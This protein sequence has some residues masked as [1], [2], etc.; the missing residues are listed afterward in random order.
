ML[1][2]DGVP[3]QLTSAAAVSWRLLVV[4]AAV[5]AATLALSE[6]RLVVLPVVVAL[7]LATFL[8]PPTRWLRR[9]GWPSS[10][11]ALTVMAAS[12]LLLAGVIAAIAPTIADELDELGSSAREGIER[13]SDWLVGGPL[14]L[15][16]QDLDRTIDSGLAQLRENGDLVAGGVLSGALI[17]LEVVAGAL[18]AVVLLFFFLKEGESMWNRLVGFFPEHKSEQVHELG[19][20]AWTT[21]GA[22]LRGISI[23]AVV[24]AVLIGIVLLVVGVPLVVPL[25]VLT[26]FG[27][28][29]PLIG[30]TL[31]GSVA[32]LVALVSQGFVS[33]LIVV[34][35]IVL[36]QQLEG[37]LLYPVVVGR[38]VELHPVV[39]LLALTAGA[40]LGGVIGAF[41]AVP[42]AA[43]ATA[44]ASYLRTRPSH[45]TAS[46][47]PHRVAAE[48][49]R[50]R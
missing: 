21:L 40:V 30:A 23:V 19:G 3:R 6:L 20:R 15:S 34:V 48:L 47:P 32:A 2:D 5:V 39:V 8:V 46:L 26:F 12:L 41:L 35:A 38:N 28:Y 27:A 31:A 16:E 25:M 36:I 9:R 18:L 50:A 14:G 24:D 13:V 1:G 7:L 37:D 10:L 43:V 49:R 11:A 42:I 45:V 17:L 29:F 22:Y 44:I 4:A 33:A